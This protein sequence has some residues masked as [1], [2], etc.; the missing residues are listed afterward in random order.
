MRWGENYSGNNTYWL[1]QNSFGLVV[2]TQPLS[3]LEKE[4]VA[5]FENVNERMLNILRGM[6][7]D[8]S[9]PL[10]RAYYW[11]ATEM[12][13]TVKIKIAYLKEIERQTQRRFP[14]IVAPVKKRGRK[15]L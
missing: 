1:I 6:E 12:I 2:S 14:L 15:K 4:V 11:N 3:T 7:Y 9:Q 8:P 5:V 10:P 13:E